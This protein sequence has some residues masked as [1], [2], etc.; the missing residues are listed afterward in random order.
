MKRNAQRAGQLNQFTR[1][2]NIHGTIW[3]ENTQRN[4][5]GTQVPGN[6]DV[7]ANHAEFLFGVAEISGTRPN[8]NMQADRDTGPNR[9]DQ[10]RARRN[11]AF[12]QVAAKFNALGA[13]ALRRDRGDD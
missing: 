12:V 13:A 5:I 8:Q 1:S 6:L 4:T 2:G 11:S 7:P 3:V 9:F 10:S